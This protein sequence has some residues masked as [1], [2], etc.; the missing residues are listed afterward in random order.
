MLNSKEEGFDLRNIC[1][2]DNRNASMLSRFS[3]KYDDGS[4]AGDK[5]VSQVAIGLLGPEIGVK[6]SSWLKDN[7]IKLGGDEVL[8]SFTER[9]R[10]KI[11]DNFTERDILNNAFE[12][13]FSMITAKGSITKKQ[14]LNMEK[15]IS[16]V[17]HDI[18][19]KAFNKLI[20]C[21]IDNEKIV[22]VL[23]ESKTIMDRFSEP[24]FK[25]KNVK[26]ETAAD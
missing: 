3:K 5:A 25:E 4:A 7:R 1:K 16:V 19:Y 20:K 12:V 18:G 26:I 2:H 9:T 6:Y 14:L 21:K 23:G 13:A 22:E 17:P 8:N 24:E 10:K 15:F 11:V